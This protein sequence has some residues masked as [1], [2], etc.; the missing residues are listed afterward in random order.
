MLE[1]NYSGKEL[2]HNVTEHLEGGSRSGIDISDWDRMVP[3]D[4]LSPVE[5]ALDNGSSTSP[6]TV[7]VDLAKMPFECAEWAARFEKKHITKKIWRKE[8]N[9]GV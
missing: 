9:N 3:Q 4:P 7:L 5:V 8:S 1:R 2:H 6:T